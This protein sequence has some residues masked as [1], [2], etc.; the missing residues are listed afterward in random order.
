M[1]AVGYFVLK[2]I[3]I[4]LVVNGAIFL[5]GA[6]I[7]YARE[8]NFQASAIRFFIA[9]ASLV[10][11]TL[12]SKFAISLRGEELQDF[13][14]GENQY[15]REFPKK[16]ANVFFLIDKAG[17]VKMPFLKEM[18]R[19]ERSKV[20]MNWGAFILG[21]FYYLALG[22]WRPAVSY[23][24]CMVTF[25]LVLDHVALTYFGKENLRISGVAAGFIWGML[26]NVN[27]YKMKVLGEKNW[28]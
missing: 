17:G 24:L 19:Q 22:M 7:G 12:I 1:K 16:W 25:F 15:E 26:A 4:I 5:L 2:A 6:F 20:R 23:L 8:G 18:S 13:S 9:I 21:P 14:T 27:Y 28:F 10:F 11:G 3:A